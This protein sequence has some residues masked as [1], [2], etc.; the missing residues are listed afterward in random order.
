MNH[1]MFNKMLSA[2]LA[3]VLCIGMVPA[4]AI[5]AAAASSVGSNEWI[6]RND[7]FSRYPTGTD[8]FWQNDWYTGFSS[9]YHGIYESE[10]YATYDIVAEGENKMLQMVTV[11]P[12]D[13][14][15]VLNPL[16]ANFTAPTVSGAWS[17]SIDLCMVKP[18]GKSV[19]GLSINM[20]T[21]ISPSLSGGVTVYVEPT[22]GYGVRLVQ[23]V[24]TDV[25]GEQRV[26]D[27]NGDMVIAYDTWYTLKLSVE[28][29][30]FMVKVWPQDQA[31]PA[32][33]ATTGVIVFEHEAFTQ[34]RLDNGMAAVIQGRGREDT[35]VPYK[36]R[37]DNLKVA[38]PY[39]DMTLPDSLS[40]E[41]GE[42]LPI[43]PAFTGQ[44]LMAQLPAP[45]FIY[46][47]F[48]PSLGR[49]TP[50]GYLALNTAGQGTVTVEL[51]DIDGNGTGVT[52][53][54]PLTVSASTAGEQPLRIL[55]IGNGYSR[56]TLYYL[57]NLAALVGQSVDSAYLTLDNATLRY[58]ARNVAQ[59]AAEYNYYASATN[60]TAT[61]STINDVVESENWDI[62]MLQ[63][64]VE[65]AGMPNTYDA[66]L[67]YLLD[68]LADAQPKAKVYWN[69]TWA[70][71]QNTVNRTED[72]KS[73][74]DSEQGVMYNAI[75]NALDEYIVGA[76][77]EFGADFD[78][79]FPVGAAIQNLRATA[80][81]DT[82]TR[83]GYH[84]SLQAGRLTAAMTV[85]KVLFPGVD[86]SAITPTAVSSFLVTNKMDGGQTFSGDPA[87]TNNTTNMTLI[88]QSVE[89][90]CAD[91]NKAPATVAAPN[92]PKVEDVTPD[93]DDVT[94]GQVV[95]PLNLRFADI[96]VTQDGTVYAGAYESVAHV[97]TKD[98]D[99]KQTGKEGYGELKIWKGDPDGKTWYFDEPLLT[100][101]Q[102][103]LEEWGI[104][105]NLYKRYDLLKS[106][107]GDYAYFIDARDANLGLMYHDMDNDGTE[108]EVLLFTFFANLFM[109]SGGTK[110]AGTF[111]LHSIDGGETW[112]KPQRISSKVLDTGGGKRGDIAV[113]SDGQILFP[114]YANPKVSG[115]LL[116]WNVDTKQWDTEYETEIPM[117]VYTTEFTE[118]S[119]IAPD[120]DGQVVYGFV[121]DNGQAVVSYDRGYTWEHIH[122]IDGNVEQPGWAYIDENRAF[123]TWAF[124]NG[125]ARD[126]KGQMVYFDAGWEATQPKV[127]H[128]NYYRMPHDAGDPSSKLLQN[129]KLLTIMYDVTFRAINGKFLDPD[130]PEF[131]LP[132][133]ND[134]AAQVT[135]RTVTPGSVNLTV[136]NDLPFTHT[137]NFTATFAADGK[138]TITAANGAKVE[139]AVG[140]YGIKTDKATEL[141][142]A[143]VNG[144]T[145]VKTWLVGSTEPADWTAVKGGTDQNSGKA[146]FVGSAVT[147]GTVKVTR[148]ATLIMGEG[149]ATTAGMMGTAPLWMNP[150]EMADKVTWTTSD[151]AIA[152]VDGQGTVKF[153]GTGTVTITATLGDQS[154]S[155]TYEVGAAAAEVMGEGE[156][157]IL[158]EDDF[159]SYTAG[160]NTFYD[161]M[162]SHGYTTPAEYAKTGFNIVE[163][164]DNKYLQLVST[165]G[166]ANYPWCVVDTPVF[167]DY[168][169][170]FDFLYS[171]A[172]T[173]ANIYVNMWHDVDGI[174]SMMQMGADRFNYQ[175]ID[176]QTGDYVSSPVFY[177]H[178]VGTWN[179]MKLARVDGGMYAK[180]WPKGAPEPAGWQYCGLADEMDTDNAAKF[181]L[182]FS[183]KETT[184]QVALFDNLIITKLR[185]EM[186]NE[187]VVRSDDFSDC[188]VGQDEFWNNS[189]Y[190]GFSESYHTYTEGGFPGFG[191]TT[192]S[193]YYNVIKENSD[194]MLELVSNYKVA[195]YFTTT[196]VSGAYSMTLDLYMQNSTTGTSVPG[197]KLSLL[198]GISSGLPGVYIDG[199]N[200]TNP[201]NT[202]RLVENFEE[203][204]N[205]STL[206]V[207][208]ADGTNMVPTVD[209]WFTVKLTV[210]PGQFMLKVW[211]R[212]EQEPEDDSAAGVCVLKHDGLTEEL[213]NSE[214][215]GS[216]ETRARNVKNASYAVRI[217][218]LKLSKP[219]KSLG[220]P[221]QLSGN[222][223]DTVTLDPKFTGQDLAAQTP[224][225]T[226]RY[227]ASEPAVTSVSADGVVTFGEVGQGTIGV[228]LLDMDGK[229]HGVAHEISLT[230]TEV[231][232]PEPEPDPDPEPEPEPEQHST[233]GTFS[234]E[235][236]E[237]IIINNQKVDICRW[238]WTPLDA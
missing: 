96:V 88:R 118:P 238:V 74:Y 109:E 224:A 119:F 28:L 230:V 54:I 105:P 180:V 114:M 13:T 81:G 192:Y 206:H 160:T 142:V 208:N 219:Y 125:P 117:Y 72:F 29:G 112:S 138:L 233:R 225:P 84:L 237:T 104:A 209:T 176:A 204:T 63:Q 18:S 33:D 35:G 154:V 64:G 162:A 236:V 100:I 130:A 220:L 8:T 60:N 46:T 41:S 38:K 195:N 181:R 51:A 183:A 235:V 121:R 4:T 122:T 234:L 110:F 55:S 170:Q 31:E 231:S 116:Q 135:L 22:K 124:D 20:F 44:D 101:G 11:N 153:V 75:V 228:E 186:D 80:F 61:V 23:S 218:N 52:R 53:R 178:S 76:D 202:F 120:P 169:A 6:V 78:G 103:E 39:A 26:Q 216:I 14:E 15:G 133:L 45:K 98:K 197:V 24:T 1:K 174:Y 70:H 50:N 99:Y 175:H 43:E 92:P 137:L 139:F 16:N 141:R 3:I 19:P 223:G 166:N 201:G 232:E 85:L 21:G 90:A 210:E 89:A 91:L 129:G 172:N 163:E 199:V 113:F 127:I 56:D 211:P 221:A 150:A 27:A 155:A 144:A 190:S 159:E 200:S 2:L 49:V 145:Y 194:E 62:I 177:S 147:L 111:L 10:N 188:T 68:Y 189:K 213:L 40:G 5:P 57:D 65:E 165:S 173:D 171:A 207:K 32:D 69:M 149:G 79:W 212:G 94:I 222:P 196:K 30:K 191:G 227:I 158:F 107:V 167:G 83:D 66:D 215:A 179:T 102:H 152:T 136:G 161:A 205:G 185:P 71:Q 7:D 198:N 34:E 140:K 229:S 115:V 143:V 42:I 226:I 168:T 36:V 148:R 12:T 97:P 132:E 86:L 157:K 203:P 128:E 108:D 67:R 193:S 182:S 37:L 187:W 17:L 59:N 47:V 25:G 82:L 58:H 77:A 184:E 151:P 106:G 9:G 156:T 146:V 214:K 123:A 95:A 131:Q 134:D 164:N 87:Y 48:D 217:D 93:P 73:L 126:T